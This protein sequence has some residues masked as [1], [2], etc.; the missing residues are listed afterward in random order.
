MKLS[1][2][3]S[4]IPLNEK[5]NLLYNALGDKFI[6]FK[7]SLDKYLSNE[8][9]DK[10]KIESPEF[11]S[12]L[13]DSRCIVKKDLKEQVLLEELKN[14]VI[15]NDTSYFLM[16]NPTLACNF[17]CWYCY[18]D[19]IP[20][21]KMNDDMIKR[22]KLLIENTIS[23]NKK[24]K[25]MSLSFFGGEPLLN[26]KENVLPIISFFHTTCLK[27]EIEP[28]ISFTSNGYLIKEEFISSFKE[29]GVRYFQ[30]TLDG[31]REQHNTVRYVNK[32]KGSYDVILKN[33]KLLLQDEIVVRIRL[34]YTRDNILGIQNVFNDINNLTPEMKEH[35]LIDLHQVW[36]DKENFPEELKSKVDEVEDLFIRNGFKTTSNKSFDM[37]RNPCYADVKNSVL[38]NYNGDLF[39]CTARDFISE[40]RSGYLDETGKL[41]WENDSLNKRTKVKFINK[42]CQICRIAPLCGGCSQYIL[43]QRGK[44]FCVLNHNQ[45]EIDEKILTRF[46]ELVL[47]GNQDEIEYEM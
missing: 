22:V 16:L 4:S 11:F 2:Y 9:L 18:E 33:I 36:Q 41:I 42:D 26:Y 23:N 6:V 44:D 46:D 5:Y 30:I 1:I 32:N 47:R 35:V 27:N 12:Q 31:D 17:K 34:N 3:N 39:K 20:G 10:L 19:H 29:F 37:V 28:Y 13:V 7:K 8:N 21:S 38:V 40:N 24:L 43:D 45:E 25:G 15:H 14:T